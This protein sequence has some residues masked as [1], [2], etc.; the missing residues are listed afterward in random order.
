MK[1]QRKIVRIFSRLN[2]GGPSLH[3]VNLTRSL[4][5]F[6]YHTTLVTGTLGGG[7]GDFQSYAVERGV[8]PY[9]IRELVPEISP[10]NDLISFFRLFRFLRREKPDIVHTHTFKAGLLGR[11]AA[12]C[13]GV[14]RIDHTYHG[15]LLKGY[16]GPGG[17]WVLR[18][19]ER[20]LARI[21]SRVYAVSEQVRKDLIESGVCRSEQISTLQLGF[22]ENWTGEQL[23]T[24]PKLRER[25]G[26]S[27]EHKL[28]GIVGRLVAVKAVD[29]FLRAAVPLLDDLRDLHL[30]II[31]DGPEKKELEKLA[32]LL[33]GS[34]EK[35]R[36]I[37]F[38]GWIVPMLPHFRDL[39]LCVCSSKNEGTSVSLIEALLS[40]VPVISTDV[41]G[42]RDL[43]DGGR[44]GRLVPRSEAAL[45]A[46][47]IESITTDGSDSK[48]IKTSIHFMER[49]S[50]KGLS[51]KLDAS[52][53]DWI[54]CKP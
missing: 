51:Q 34:Q 29:L 35:L 8:Q 11:M 21:T 39:D 14:K 23:R 9:F 54:P 26:L 17:T 24:K 27:R 50:L 22:D 5:A 46:A 10:I 31:G 4:E 45:R 47:M 37:H 38:T 40:D 28:V 19:L 32:Q 33:T 53:R 18:L 12:W 2:V 30:V 44:W 3:V 13:A 36:R 25:L 7:E 52:Y 43:L 1:Y 48:R 41:G 6:G 15:H 20:M 49:Y 16:Y 42:M